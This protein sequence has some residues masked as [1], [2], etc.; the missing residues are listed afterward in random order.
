[1]IFGLSLNRFSRDAERRNLEVSLHNRQ[2][3]AVELRE[4]AARV[5]IG[6]KGGSSDCYISLHQQIALTSIHST[7]ID[8]L[9]DAIEGVQGKAQ[10]KRQFD[11]VLCLLVYHP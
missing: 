1:M 3:V 10:P 11:A 9:H 5:L 8:A 4:P 6:V 7:R 2:D